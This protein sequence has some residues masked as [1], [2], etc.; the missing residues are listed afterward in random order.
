MKRIFFVHWNA[1]EAEE[2]AGRLREAG[3]DVD[4]YWKTDNTGLGH[5]RAN[6][7]DLILVDLSR[8]PSHGRGVATFLRRQKATRPVPVVFVGGVPEKVARIREALPDAVY[9]EWRGIRSALR[10]A[11]ASAPPAPVVP[12]TTM[13]GYSGTPLA[14]KLGIRAGSVVALLHA[15]PGFAPQIEPLPEGVR[16]QEKPA[17]ASRMLLFARSQADLARRFPAAERALPE[18]GG[19]W[20]CWPKKASGIASDLS[21][22]AVRAFGLARGLVDYKICAVDATWSGLCF[23]RRRKAKD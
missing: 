22:P 14:K 21:E 9:A 17:G 8:V 16:L 23:A 18:K 4:P 2:R 13:A 11:L 20:I 6:P 12:P 1:A 3:Y 10:Q 15:P 19:L 5:L 7:P